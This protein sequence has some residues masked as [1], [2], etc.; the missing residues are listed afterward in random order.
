[1]LEPPLS[2]AEQAEAGAMIDRVDVADRLR[3]SFLSFARS[4]RQCFAGNIGNL[5]ALATQQ[6]FKY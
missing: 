5:M 1:V 2:A 6:A 3:I 4:L